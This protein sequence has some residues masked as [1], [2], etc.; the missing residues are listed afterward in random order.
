[1]GQA[2]NATATEKRT[3][4]HLVQSVELLFTGKGNGGR[5]LIRDLTK[6]QYVRMQK[7]TGINFGTLIAIREKQ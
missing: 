2:I 1:M 6:D 4:E 7:C 3:K 5:D